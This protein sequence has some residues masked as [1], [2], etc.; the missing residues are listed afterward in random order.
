MLSETDR[1]DHWMVHWVLPSALSRVDWTDGTSPSRFDRGSAAVFVVCATY[2]LHRMYGVFGTDGAS[3]VAAA[4]RGAPTMPVSAPSASSSRGEV[5][6]GVDALT[7]GE[8]EGG[9]SA[10]PRPAGDPLREAV[11]DGQPANTRE[12]A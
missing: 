3:S 4:S 1:R 11:V 12:A 10:C 9:T 2:T 5:S 7:R 8:G 6:A